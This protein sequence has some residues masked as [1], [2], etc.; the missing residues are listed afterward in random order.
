MDGIIWDLATQLAIGAYSPGMIQW[1]SMSACTMKRRLSKSGSIFIQH[2]VEEATQLG[3]ASFKWNALVDV[4]T[5]AA[6]SEQRIPSAGSE[7]G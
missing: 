4:Q 1:S 3:V 2:G 5:G 6:I 7:F